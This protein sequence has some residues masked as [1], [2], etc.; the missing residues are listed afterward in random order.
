MSKERVQVR[1]ADLPGNKPERKNQRKLTEAPPPQVASAVENR[2]TS[3]TAGPSSKLLA[4][5]WAQREL[6]K[7]HPERLAQLDRFSRVIESRSSSSPGPLA[8]GTKSR[9]D[10]K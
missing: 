4:E 8:E 3:G 9:K 2:Q 1:V 10:A 7:D 6:L 5:L